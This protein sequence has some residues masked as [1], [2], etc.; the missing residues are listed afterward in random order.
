MSG[1]TA[2][3][4]TISQGATAEVEQCHS[5]KRLKV[6]VKERKENV[7]NVSQSVSLSVFQ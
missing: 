2:I 3:G 6:K 5:I 4:P 7:A 1:S